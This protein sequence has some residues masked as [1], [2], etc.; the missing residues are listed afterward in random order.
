ME[1]RTRAEELCDGDRE[2]NASRKGLLE[3]EAASLIPSN[4]PSA[5]SV[6]TLG[7]ARS[8]DRPANHDGRSLTWRLHHL[9]KSCD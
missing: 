7:P 5:V 6:A 2:R 1:E 4:T 9:F 8:C 3:G